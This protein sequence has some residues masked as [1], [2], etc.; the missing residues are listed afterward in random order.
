M[1][2]RDRGGYA[3]GGHA[4]AAVDAGTGRVRGSRR[5]DAGLSAAT[6]ARLRVISGPAQLAVAGAAGAIHLRTVLRTETRR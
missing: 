1:H 6:G 2:D 3:Q 5:I 4:M